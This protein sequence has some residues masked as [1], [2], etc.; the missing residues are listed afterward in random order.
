MDTATAQETNY[1][2]IRVSIPFC[3]PFRLTFNCGICDFYFL[4]PKPDKQIS[5]QKKNE[6]KRFQLKAAIF[7]IR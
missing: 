2:F 4:L 6:Q 7:T 5:T 1:S 3:F